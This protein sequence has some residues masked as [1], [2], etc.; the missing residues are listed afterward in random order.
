MLQDSRLGHHPGR[1][2]FQASL[3]SSGCFSDHVTSLKR[4]L[5]GGG[6]RLVGHESKDAP[7]NRNFKG[8]CNH[9]TEISA[10]QV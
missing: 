1:L 5:G 3:G 8:Q 4:P 7:Q 2:S 10:A 6:S 9:R